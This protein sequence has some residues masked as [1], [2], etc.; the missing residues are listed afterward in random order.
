[1]SS[2][3]HLLE[4]YKFI[5]NQGFHKTKKI[6]A[7]AL[8]VIATLSVLFYVVSSKYIEVNWY[9]IVFIIIIYIASLVLFFIPE[10]IKGFDQDFQEI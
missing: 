10:K 7:M 1:M 4:D 8:A 6:A 2:H 3:S 5:K 9:F